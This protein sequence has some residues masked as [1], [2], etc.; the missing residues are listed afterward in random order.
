MGE[1]VVYENGEDLRLNVRTDGETVWLT[2][3]QMCKLLGRNQSVI[4]RHIGNALRE[5][6][7]DDSNIMQILHNN[8]RGQPLR[9]LRA[10]YSSPDTNDQPLATSH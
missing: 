1:I 7:L 5:G 4:S 2:Q 8:R 10:S 3:E 9:E 6:E